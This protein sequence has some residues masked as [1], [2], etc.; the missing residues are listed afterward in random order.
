MEV[1]GL[2]DRFAQNLRGPTR[3]NSRLFF[4]HFPGGEVG[5]PSFDRGEKLRRHGLLILK[6]FPDLL[7]FAEGQSRNGRLDLCKRGS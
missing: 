7:G 4:A 1:R 5:F 3:H 6:P 2:N